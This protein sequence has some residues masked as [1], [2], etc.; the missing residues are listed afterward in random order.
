MTVLHWGFE[1]NFTQILA[2][3][4]YLLHGMQAFPYN[5]CFLPVPPSILFASTLPFPTF[6]L[7]VL[8]SFVG[9]GQCLWPV[10]LSFSPELY[11]ISISSGN[12]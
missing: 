12:D 4:S 3:Q 5:F 10:R 8:L 1:H 2:W 7:A 6:L 9:Q 11:S